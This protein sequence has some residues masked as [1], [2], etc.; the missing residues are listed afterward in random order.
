MHLNSGYRAE[1][2]A[3]A[4]RFVRVFGEAGADAVL[5]PS[6]SC[7]TM[8]REHYAPLAARSGDHGLAAEVEALALDVLELSE[9]LVGRLGVEEVG[10]YYP[11]G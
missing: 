11:T 5:T 8:V 6:G 4:R 3:L 2:E 7:A 10:A 1:A 9:L